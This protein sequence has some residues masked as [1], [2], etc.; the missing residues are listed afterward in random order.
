MQPLAYYEPGGLLLALMHEQDPAL[1]PDT[2]KD[3]GTEIWIYD[4]SNRRLKHR[5]ALIRP[6]SAIQ[7]SQGER[8]LLYAAS[9]VDDTV[10]IYDLKT[11]RLLGT[12]D[13]LGM[14]TLLQN[15]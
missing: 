11:T 10:D 6:A 7:V 5:L 4:V 2:H 15:L 1:H 8:P 3:P 9:V 13:E 14:P 12:L